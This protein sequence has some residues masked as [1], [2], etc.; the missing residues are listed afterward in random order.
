M[1]ATHVAG[2]HW[3]TFTETFSSFVNGYDAVIYAVGGTVSA[4]MRQKQTLSRNRLQSIPA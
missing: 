1:S 3:R 4:K 2:I